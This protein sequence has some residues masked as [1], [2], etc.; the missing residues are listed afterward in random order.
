MWR[1]MDMGGADWLISYYGLISEDK[2]G[3]KKDNEIEGEGTNDDQEG[4]EGFLILLT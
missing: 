2:T 3:N 1:S 4:E